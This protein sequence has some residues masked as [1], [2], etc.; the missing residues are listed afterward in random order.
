MFFSCQGEVAFYGAD[1]AGGG[2]AVAVGV[3][4]LGHVLKM[5][6]VVQEAADCGEYFF[7]VGADEA[8]GACFDGFGAFGDGAQDQH[9]F[10][11]RRGLF[12][13]AAGIGEDKPRSRY[14]FQEREIRL[15]WQ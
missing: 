5:S 4:G 14:E 8:D 6:F 12:L 9:G 10:A 15:R 13:D 3:D 2:L 11:Q 7:P 1:G